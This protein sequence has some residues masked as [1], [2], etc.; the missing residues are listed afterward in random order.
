M[1]QLNSS[2]TCYLVYDKKGYCA[3]PNGSVR[4]GTAAA[5]SMRWPS[6]K[7]TYRGAY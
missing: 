3:S 7:H 4:I 5:C 6:T 1:Y 2:G